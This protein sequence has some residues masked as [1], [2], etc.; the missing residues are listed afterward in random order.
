[1]G[2]K[3]WESLPG[4]KQLGVQIGETSPKSYQFRG[5]DLINGAP[6]FRYEVDGVAITETLSAS[7]EAVSWRFTVDSPDDDVRVLGP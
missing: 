3:I 2:E 6:S 4:E 7:K 5:Y 1:M